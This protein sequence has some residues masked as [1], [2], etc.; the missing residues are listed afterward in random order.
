MGRAAA[1]ACMGRLDALGLCGRRWDAQTNKRKRVCFR[2]PIR[3]E[4]TPFNRG[5]MTL[6]RAS[7]RSTAEGADNAD[8]T[9]TMAP[10]DV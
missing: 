8:I 2:E 6:T 1:L 4:N 3:S 10:A 9:H 7:A 5:P